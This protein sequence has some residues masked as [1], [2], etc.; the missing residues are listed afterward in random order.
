[1]EGTEF[2]GGGGAFVLLGVGAVL[3]RVWQRTTEPMMQI[4]VIVL[5]RAHEHLGKANVGPLCSLSAYRC[6]GP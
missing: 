3:E 1:M 4:W 5:G 2:G 6:M